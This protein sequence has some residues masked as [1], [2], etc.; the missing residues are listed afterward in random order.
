MGFFDKVVNFFKAGTPDDSTAA[1]PNSCEGGV[2]RGRGALRVRR[3]PR[4]THRAAACLRLSQL[5]LRLRLR[6]A[7]VA[8]SRSLLGDVPQQS[9]SPSSS[10]PILQRLE[11]SKPAHLDMGHVSPGGP[12]CVLLPTPRCVF[13]AHTHRPL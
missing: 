7:V 6:T 10:K 1:N 8:S 12:R 13:P 4:E 3:D 2:R 9:L 5:G 11:G